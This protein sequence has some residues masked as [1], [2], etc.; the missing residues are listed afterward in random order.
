LFEIASCDEIHQIPPGDQ[1]LI[2]EE[3][4][5]EGFEI[6]DTGVLRLTVSPIDPNAR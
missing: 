4:Q 2:K 1:L 5:D 3:L 6:D